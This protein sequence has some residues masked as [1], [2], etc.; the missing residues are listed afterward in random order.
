MIVQHLDPNHKSLMAI[1]LQRESKIKVKEAENGEPIKAG[2]AYIA[3]PNK[4]MLATQ[5]H[6][7]L[8]MTAFVHFSRPSIDLLLESVAASY[9]G[10]SIGVILTGTG[11]DGSIGIKAIKELGGLTIA[12][13]KQ[14]SEQ[15]G[16]PDSAIKTGNVDMILPIQEIGPAIIKLVMDSRGDR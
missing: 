6:I 10:S 16:M 9:D 15:F 3:P 7:E 11:T 8:T 2:T 4:H 1:L 14:T 12:Q 5:G 13:D